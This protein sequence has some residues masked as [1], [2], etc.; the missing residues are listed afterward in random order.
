LKLREREDHVKLSIV[1][2]DRY[3]YV[4]PT[5]ILDQINP[6]TRAIVINHAS[7]VV[8]AVT[9]IEVISEIA[10]DNDIHLIIDASQSAGNIPIDI[11]KIDPDILI[12]TG[13]K[14]LYGIAGIGGLYIKEGVNVKPLIVGGTGL[15]T[16]SLFQTE[17]KPA[18]YESGTQNIVGIASLE[19]G[20]SF[21]LETG[22]EKINQKKEQIF[23]KMVEAFERIPG[24]IMY[25]S[26]EY[27][28]PLLSFNIK[29]ADPKSVGYI[30]NHKYGIIVRTGLL[31]APLIHKNIGTESTGGAVRISFSS[32][33]QEEEIEDL[34]CAVK[35]II[36]LIKKDGEL[37][38]TSKLL[39]C[40]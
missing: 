7:N 39:A 27:S 25:G 2:C 33:T 22:M 29:D 19:A 24:I 8:N 34:I 30:L 21:I 23:Y 10:H 4:S 32:F 14:S 36:D 11:G 13:H 40:Y 35:D 37:V 26:R 5:D 9:D 28:L 31:C 18:Y 6:E 38:S 20:I 16:Q 15:K 17:E 1:E 3:G 12:F